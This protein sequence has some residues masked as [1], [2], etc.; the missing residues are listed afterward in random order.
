MHFFKVIVAIILFTTLNYSQ[1]IEDVIRVKTNVVRVPVI[2]ETE[3]RQFVLS[4]HVNNKQV[5]IENLTEPSRQN[6]KCVVIHISSGQKNI[7]TYKHI[8]EKIQETSLNT[9]AWIE[10][11]GQV[12]DSFLHS[13][14]KHHVEDI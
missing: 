14:E 5:N 10:V 8:L 12:A 3:I 6:L 7:A 11:G 9:S 4:A 1:T 2:I 13:W